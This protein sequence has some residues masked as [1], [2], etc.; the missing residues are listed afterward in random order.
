MN[1]SANS[2]ALLRASDDVL[3]RIG[4]NLL[5][6][7]RIE[8]NLKRLMAHA[9]IS[10]PVSAIGKIIKKQEADTE[11]GM[12]GVLI[13]KYVETLLTSRSD[14]E[15]SSDEISEPHITFSI[16]FDLDASSVKNERESLKAL[17]A[18]RNN[19]V[20]HF[21]EQH[22]LESLEDCSTACIWLDSQYKQASNFLHRIRSIMYAAAEARKEYIELVSS[23][24]FSEYCERSF[25]QQSLLIAE[26]GRISLQIAR[27]DG[28]SVFATAGG[29][30]KQHMPEEVAALKP[31]YGHKTLKSLILATELFDIAEEPTPGGG[32]R[33]LYRI[34]PV[35]GGDPYA[36]G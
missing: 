33:L 17:S 24:K 32:N 6:L 15:E 8:T 27:P 2:E 1:N 28:W 14:Q 18:G 34:K 5:V 20:H 11:Y 13:K 10:G 22:D 7:Q 30:L 35:T 21:L 26:L 12:F 9:H 4:R 31:R 36:N 3:V 25:L 19:L 16:K 29:R 23:G